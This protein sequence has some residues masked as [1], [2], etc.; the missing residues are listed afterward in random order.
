MSHGGTFDMP[1]G[2]SPPEW[3]F[4]PAFADY[5]HRGKNKKKTKKKLGVVWGRAVFLLKA[6]VLDL[7]N[8]NGEESDMQ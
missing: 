5:C 3:G 1:A 6:M 8:G 2:P 7:I 4:P